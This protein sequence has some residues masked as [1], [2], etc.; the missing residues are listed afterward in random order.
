MTDRTT[1]AVKTKTSRPVVYLAGDGV[2]HGV[3]GSAGAAGCDPCN[4]LVA[5][6]RLAKVVAYLK[7]RGVEVVSGLP[8]SVR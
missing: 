1:V 5:S 7:S 2:T 4:G 6:E 8:P 3:T